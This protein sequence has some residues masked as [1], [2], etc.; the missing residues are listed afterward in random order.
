MDRMHARRERIAAAEAQ[1]IVMRAD[2][3]RLFGMRAV[4]FEHAEHVFHR[5]LLPVD[6][7]LAGDP[8]AGQLAALRSRSGIDLALERRQIGAERGLHGLVDG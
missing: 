6:I 1:M 8:P 7:R 3:D 5:R 2:H 4:P